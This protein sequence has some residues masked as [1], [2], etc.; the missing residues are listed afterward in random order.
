M[1]C[2][3][4]PKEHLG[5]PNNK[6]VKD[7][8]IAYKIAAHAADLA[9]GHP[10]AQLPRCAR[11]SGSLRLAVSAS[12]RLR[13]NALSKARFD[14]SRLGSGEKDFAERKADRLRLRAQPS[15]FRPSINS[16]SASTQ[17]SRSLSMRTASRLTLIGRCLCGDVWS[18][19]LAFGLVEQQNVIADSGRSFGFWYRWLLAASA[20][21]A[22]FGL[23]VALAPD[24]FIFDF[25]NRQLTARFWGSTEVPENVREVRL[26]LFGPLGGT[27]AGK[28]VLL[29]YAVRFGFKRRERWAWWAIL[30]SHLAWFVIDSSV[31]FYHRAY[32]NILLINITPV[33]V[34]GIPLLFTWKYFQRRQPE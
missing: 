8:V 18:D 22:V 11:P 25:Y 30:I 15:P 32:F 34:Y 10:G 12:L 23:I 28:Y 9:K 14:S 16:T 24:S 17:R 29:F 21:F 1:L 33:I 26:F 5:L 6:D 2:P 31:S 27:I 7:G 19:R 20:F 3:V 13:D 4:T